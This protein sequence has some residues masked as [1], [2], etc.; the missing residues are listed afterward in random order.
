MA[1]RRLSIDVDVDT[2]RAVR[3]FDDVGDAARD[4][5]RDVDRASDDVVRRSR[6][7]AGSV[8]NVGSSAAQAA[9]G[10]GD[11]GGALSTVPGP[12]G[13]LGAGMES[14][15][16]VIMGVTGAADLCSLAMNSNAL[17]STRAKLA[18]IG[19][20]I[21]EKAGALAT[22]AMAAGQW[23]LNAAMSA[24]PIG[25]I[26]LAVVALV[27][28]FVLLYKRSE[29]VRAITAK[30]GEALATAGRWLFDMG[31]KVA[32]FL[33]KWSPMGIAIRLI[34]DNFAQVT[35]KIRELAGWLGEK[36]GAQLTAFKTAAGVVGR[37]M[38][39]TFAGMINAVTSPFRS[40]YN[41]I[42]DVIEW[43]GK[44]KVPKALEKIGGALGGLIGGSSV[45]TVVGSPQ[46]AGGTGSM[47]RRRGTTTAAVGLP[48]FG[49][50]F[51]QGNADVAV[52]PVLIDQRTYVTVD[53]ALDPVAVGDQL[54]E[55]IR[56]AQRRRPAV[57][58]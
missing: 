31:K 11:L 2:R 23:A 7:I 27:A 1:D 15:A 50:L 9:G 57:L 21:A 24:N 17:A 45:L 20:T 26:V 29:T 47:D 48:D 34:R 36:I 33:L 39:D 16:P 6:D 28:G 8:D 56:R 3:G 49:S 32:A 12:L 40:L 46:L 44:I 54:L 18:T 35:G 51:G 53:G 52:R 42:K 10:L 19:K 4:M 55:I 37:W 30:V 58:L 14:A 43:L 38:R 25:L 41:A 5:G 22:K 13:D